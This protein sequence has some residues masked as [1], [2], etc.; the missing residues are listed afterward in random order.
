MSAAEAG[1]FV[2]HYDRGSQRIHEL[3]VKVRGI[4]RLL[5]VA[6]NDDVAATANL[7]AQA[8]DIGARIVG[9]EETGKEFDV[10]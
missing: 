1:S 8:R 9:W 5:S 10:T 7:L 4:D 6:G 3:K 2:T